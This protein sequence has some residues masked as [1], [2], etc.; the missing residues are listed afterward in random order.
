MTNSDIQQRFVAA[1][2]AGD[3]ATLNALCHGEFVLEQGGGM[4]Y[5]ETYRGAEG[6][7]R[8]LGIFGETLDIEKL[9]PVRTY[10]C[11]DPDWLVSEF[12]LVATV[13]ATGQHYV[14]TLLERWQF[15]EG[16]VINIKPHYFEPPTRG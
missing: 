1:V 7:L 8:F 2:F 14:T 5:G 16:K 13:K 12:D 15:S 10:E 11:S 3:A 4:P 9:E 6:F